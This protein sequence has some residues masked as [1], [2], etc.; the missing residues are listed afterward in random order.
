MMAQEEF[1]CHQR[2]KPEYFVTSSQTL[3]AQAK[4]TIGRYGAI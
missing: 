2:D 4:G 1:R 3:G